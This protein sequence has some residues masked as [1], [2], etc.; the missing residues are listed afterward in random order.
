[1]IGAM[2]W[3][4]SWCCMASPRWVVKKS[5]AW[6]PTKLPRMIAWLRWAS[7]AGRD[8]TATEGAGVRAARTRELSAICPGSDIAPIDLPSFAACSLTKRARCLAVIGTKRWLYS[9]GGPD[10]YGFH[11]GPDQG[12]T[13][14]PRHHRGAAKRPL[15]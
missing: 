15:R 7:G 14:G 2:N 10:R 1:M 3:L 12:A 6:K 8:D 4:S 13:E 11:R 5:R 9:T